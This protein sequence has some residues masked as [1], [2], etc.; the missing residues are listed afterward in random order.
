MYFCVCIVFLQKTRMYNFCYTAT[1]E[2]EKSA[3]APLQGLFG[4]NII[5][6][7]SYLLFVIDTIRYAR[8]KDCEQCIQLLFY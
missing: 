2:P 7:L 5:L 8:Y 4:M 3:M 6:C 1:Q